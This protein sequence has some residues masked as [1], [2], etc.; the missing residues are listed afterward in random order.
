MNNDTITAINKKNNVPAPTWFY[1]ENYDHIFQFDD[2][3]EYA[4]FFRVYNEV[5]QYAT[6]INANSFKTINNKINCAKFTG[7]AGVTHYVQAVV[8]N[9]RSSRVEFYVMTEA[10]K[11]QYIA[12][13]TSVATLTDSDVS[14]ITATVNNN[15]S[16]NVSSLDEQRAFM[17]NAKKISNDKIMSPVVISIDTDVVVETFL[18][19]FSSNTD[20]FYLA[21]AAYNDVIYNKDIYKVPF[22]CANETVTISPLYNGIKEN[23]AY[24]IWIE[25]SNN[26]QISNSSSFTYTP[27]TEITDDI[28]AYEV[29]D[30]INTV[31]TIAK[32]SLTTD[33][34]STIEGTIENNEG[35]TSNEI[36]SSAIEI[37][38][39]TAMLK[40][41]MLNFLYSLKYYIGIYCN[42]DTTFLTDIQYNT[43]YISFNTAKTGTLLIYD[44]DQIKNVTLNT[45][46]TIYLNDYDANT[47]VIV[48]IDS[49]LNSKSSIIVVN[50]SDKYMEVL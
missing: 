22:T 14:K 39:S 45:N 50:K 13:Q 32:N 29:K 40:E 16:D 12:Q 21:I 33:M 15:L 24:C 4:E 25:D 28:T 31:N 30:L 10:E 20:T 18:N 34:Q 23:N 7:K 9:V 37:V 49:S 44:S 11:Q 38:T 8:D 5:E 6:T 19:N 17:I 27:G 35:I 47:L 2:N 41:Y 43:S 46:N 3:I 26:T 1:D 42:C 36:I 48:A